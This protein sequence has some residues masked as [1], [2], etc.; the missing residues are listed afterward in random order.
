MISARY[1]RHLPRNGTR[2]GWA[3]HHALSAAVHLLRPAQVEQLAERLD[4]GA[5]HRPDR[6]RRHLAGRHRQ[7]RLVEE[8]DAALRLA[9]RDQALAAAQPAERGEIGVA[10]PLGH[11]GDPLEQLERG[12]RVAGLQR[13]QTLGNVEVA[14]LDH[15][16]TARVEDPGRAGVPAPGLGELATLAEAHHQVEG[17]VHRARGLAV[18]HGRVVRPLPGACRLVRAPDHMGAEGEPLEIVEP[19]WRSSVGFGQVAVGVAP[20]L[21]DDGVTPRS[22]DPGS[23]MWSICLRPRGRAGSNP[24][25]SPAVGSRRPAR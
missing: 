23:A 19:K 12:A 10:E 18:R 3:S 9:K 4:R 25:T 11:R 14:S 15:V 17:V 20:R 6:D 1:T 7:H 21:S 13:Q 2:S 24:T 8:G 5:V 22:S 16:E